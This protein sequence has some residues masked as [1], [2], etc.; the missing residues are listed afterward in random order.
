MRGTRSFL[1]NKK[2]KETG[3]KF[4]NSSRKCIYIYARA[5]LWEYT[6]LNARRTAMCGTAGDRR[7][8]GK[9]AG[10]SSFWPFRVQ[11]KAFNYV[12]FRVMARG[13]GERSQG[14]NTKAVENAV[15]GPAIGLYLN[16]R[17]NVV[18]YR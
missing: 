12:F 11:D 4:S 15:S 7:A 6:K 13:G 1:R 5:I 16:A 10:N 9:S 18:N 14:A 3:E 8:R 2:K 17:I